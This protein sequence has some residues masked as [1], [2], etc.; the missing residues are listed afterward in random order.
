MVK[1]SEENFCLEWSLDLFNKSYLDI[2]T[3]CFIYIANP[4]YSTHGETFSKFLAYSFFIAMVGV[5][6]LNFIFLQVN[7]RKLGKA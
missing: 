5:L 7:L 4:A 3:S 6:I 1:Q 2:C